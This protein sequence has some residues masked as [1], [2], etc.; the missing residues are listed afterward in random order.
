MEAAQVA[1]F[2]I[3]AEY[4]EKMGAAGVAWGDSII[5]WAEYGEW[6]TP[7]GAIAEKFATDIADYRWPKEARDEAALLVST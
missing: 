6:C 2:V 3:S 5:P 4:N 1:Y 7:R